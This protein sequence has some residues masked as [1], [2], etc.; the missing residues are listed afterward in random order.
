MILLTKAGPLSEPIFSDIPHRGTISSKIFFVTMEAVSLFVGSASAHPEK[1]PT[2][3]SRY[4]HPY[5]PGLTSVKPISQLTPG[6][7]PRPL[8]PECWWVTFLDFMTWQARHWSV[9]SLRV[10][11]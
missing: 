1:V 11:L 9:V 7:H 3:T 5:L 8:L 6:F 2:S 10:L 4:L